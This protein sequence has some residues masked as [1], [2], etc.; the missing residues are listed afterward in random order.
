M[1]LSNL[2]GKGPTLDDL[3]HIGFSSNDPETWKSHQMAKKALESQ[4]KMAGSDPGEVVGDE[5]DQADVVGSITESVR[6]A[7]G[8]AAFML[9]EP[10]QLT[11]KRRDGG[12]AKK[13]HIGSEEFKF[14]NAY[15]GKK[16]QIIFVFKPK[17]VAD[18]EFAELNENDAKRMLMGFKDI[19]NVA[20]QSGPLRDINE[21]KKAAVLAAEREALAVRASSYDGFGSW[22]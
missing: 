8:E 5:L 17:G 7:A 22:S 14:A 4:M 21:A 9:G 10:A 1:A 11:V 12:Y 6:Q 2:T 3:T 20:T 15:M 16:G 13:S 19:L 18:Y